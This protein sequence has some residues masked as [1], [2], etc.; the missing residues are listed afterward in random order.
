MKLSRQAEIAACEIYNLIESGSLNLAEGTPIGDIVQRAMDASY[1][2]VYCNMHETI[3]ELKEAHGDAVLAQ[4][5]A[6]ARAEEAEKWR[7]IGSEILQDGTKAHLV[8]VEELYAARQEL[9]LLR[10]KMGV[11]PQRLCGGCGFRLGVSR[12]CLTENCGNDYS[13]DQRAFSQLE[14]AL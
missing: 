10:T 3:K 8:C 7:K 13:N 11:E 5:Q 14:V 6:V 1:K 9:T 4:S 12:V 2:D